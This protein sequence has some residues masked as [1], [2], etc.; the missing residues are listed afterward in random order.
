M[1]EFS[2]K[3]KVLTAQVSELVLHN[4]L[5]VLRDP[6]SSMELNKIYPKTI[7]TILLEYYSK[8]N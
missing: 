5:E 8:P 7:N 3:N 1:L 2:Y 4:D 6:M